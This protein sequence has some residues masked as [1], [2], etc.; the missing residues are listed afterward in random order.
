MA[1]SAI[2][3]TGYSVNELANTYRNDTY[4]PLSAS[5][6]GDGEP[7]PIVETYKTLQRRLIC[8]RR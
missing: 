3:Q 1:D 4:L 7:P 8:Q 6:R 2:L 5:L